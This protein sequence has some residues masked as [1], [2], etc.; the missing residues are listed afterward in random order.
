[1]C[2][3]PGGGRVLA[4]RGLGL[5]TLDPYLAGWRRRVVPA[6]G[7]FPV[8]MISNGAVDRT[9]HGWIAD[10]GVPAHLNPVRA[11]LSLAAQPVPGRRR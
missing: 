7:H 9:V 3:G 5:K 8:R 2:A 10:A 6:L 1:M 4:L 11:P